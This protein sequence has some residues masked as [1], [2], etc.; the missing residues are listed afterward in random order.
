M[1]H[2]A[3]VESV[4][5]GGP[6]AQAGVHG[7]TQDRTFQDQLV[8]PD[9]DIIVSVNGH[10]VVNSDLFIKLI[11]NYS[12]GKVVHLLDPAGRPAES[13]SRSRW[14]SAR[15]HRPPSRLVGWPAMQRVNVGHKSIADYASIVGRHLAD[16]IR[17]LAEPLRGRR[18]LH[19]SATAFGGGVAEIQYTLIP[20]LNDIGIETEWRVIQGR[21]EFFDVTK[22]IHNA[23][24]GDEKGLTAE[25]REI[26]MRY[27]QINADDL[28][29]AGRF[30]PG[31][32]AR[33]AAGR[34]ADAASRRQGEVG[35]AVPHRP[36][37]AQ[38]RGARLPAAVDRGVRRQHL[39][40]APVRASR[41]RPPP[42]R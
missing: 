1:Q 25:Q 9:G 7:G 31:G 26:F 20:L 29:D 21:D 11:D 34:A 35:M 10:P 6:A 18:F 5:P 22:T 12:A 42:V 3:L 4:S 33:P 19:L 41:R 37:D 13:T 36:V 23:L 2:G 14:A 28:T 16:E 39:P 27:N 30:R 32:R 8:R 24:Q 17:E 15:W 40:H 38:P